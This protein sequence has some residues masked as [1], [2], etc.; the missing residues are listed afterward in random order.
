MV[1]TQFHVCEYLNDC[2]YK[3]S[4]HPG[5]HSD[6]GS[7]G[8]RQHKARWSCCILGRCPWKVRCLLIFPSYVLVICTLLSDNLTYYWRKATAK[9][10][11][12]DYED[13]QP[14]NRESTGISGVAGVV[15]LAGKH[16][17]RR[18]KPKSKDLDENNDTENWLDENEEKERKAKPKT[19]ESSSSSPSLSLVGALVKEETASPRRRRRSKIPRRK[20]SYET[21]PNSG[22][23]VTYPH[24]S[25][26]CFGLNLF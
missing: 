24:P 22:L 19:L 17:R 26:K 25:K 10:K 9:T 7:C 11:G 6:R 20:D 18:T 5:F 1:V 12:R 4:D 23:E 14:Q 15:G 3:L 2:L 8:L 16:R 21:K 13:A